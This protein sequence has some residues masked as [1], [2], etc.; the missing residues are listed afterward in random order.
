MTHLRPIEIAARDRPTTP[1]AQIGFAET[2][3][4]HALDRH[5]HVRTV[6]RHPA[7]IRKIA[8]GKASISEIRSVEQNVVEGNKRVGKLQTA[9]IDVGEVEHRFLESQQTPLGPSNRPFLEE[10]NGFFP[11]WPE[12]R[13]E[14]F[15]FQDP[16]VRAMFSIELLGLFNKRFRFAR[17]MLVQGGLANPL[18]STADNKVIQPGRNFVHDLTPLPLDEGLLFWKAIKVACEHKSATGTFRCPAGDRRPLHGHS[19]GRHA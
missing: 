19:T 5:E 6:E 15:L 11:G 2:A 17:E 1:S 9:K 3:I 4:L 16:N 12:K 10:S 7:Q 8:T 14:L 18:N 13:V